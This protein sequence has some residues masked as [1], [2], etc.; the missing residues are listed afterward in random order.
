M[1]LFLYLKFFKIYKF[2]Y[3]KILFKLINKMIHTNG[4]YVYK[5][6]RKRSIVTPRFF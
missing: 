4:N 6:D 5:K 2:I 3:A 1:K